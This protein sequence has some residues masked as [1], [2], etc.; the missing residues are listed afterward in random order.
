M[1]IAVINDIPIITKIF[2]FA[3]KVIFS[4]DFFLAI[5]NGVEIR[6]AHK[7]HQKAILMESVVS[8]NLIV[9]NFDVK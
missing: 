9:V 5:K 2:S 4:L 8:Q 1:A 3:T 7:N 6:N